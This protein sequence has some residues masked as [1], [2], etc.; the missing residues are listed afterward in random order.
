MKLNVDCIRSVLLELEK[1][2]YGQSLR[3]QS[4]YS[5]LKTFDENDINYSVIMLKEAGFIDAVIVE[6]DDRSILRFVVN[7]IT[8]DGH[9]FLNNVRELSVWEKA[10]DKCSKIG[11]LSIPL[12]SDVASA[13]ISSLITSQL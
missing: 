5:S 13:I 1:I 12:L 2:P 3:P 6:S 7:D 8:W 11:S 9:Q 10:K 4:L